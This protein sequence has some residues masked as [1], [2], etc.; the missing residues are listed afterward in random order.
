M[1]LVGADG[2][3][4]RRQESRAATQLLLD[5]MAPP[6][7]DRGGFEGGG[8]ERGGFEGGGGERGGYS[9]STPEPE[10]EPLTPAE[11]LSASSS[12]SA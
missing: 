8:G 7:G 12:S 11:P 1:V 10:P 6:R 4:P 5:R 2:T 9:A 3:R